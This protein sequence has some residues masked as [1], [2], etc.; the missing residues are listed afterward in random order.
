MIYKKLQETVRESRENENMKSDIKQQAAILDYI[1]LMDN[2]VLP[3]D[4]SEEERGNE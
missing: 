4:G 3:D 2:I 1:A